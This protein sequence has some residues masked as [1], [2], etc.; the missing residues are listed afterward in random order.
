MGTPEEPLKE[1]VSLKEEF[2]HVM[3][4]DL[5][6]PQ[7]LAVLDKLVNQGNRFDAAGYLAGSLQRPNA[8][9]VARGRVLAVADAL[10]GL[11]KILGLFANYKPVKLTAGLRNLVNDREVARKKKD[12]QKSDKLRIEIGRMGFM[13]EDTPVGPVV[14]PRP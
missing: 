4:D 11:G 3:D 9:R 2:E 10:L 8:V 14:L 6:T 5:N 12:F 1:V 7:A 13:I